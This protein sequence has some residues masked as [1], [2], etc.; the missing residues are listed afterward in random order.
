MN[1]L[2]RLP[3]IGPVVA[4]VTRT[5]A[6][7]VY[8]HFDD[9][10]SNRMAGSVTFFGFLALFPLLTVALAVA[11]SVLSDSRVNTLQ[12]K[13]AEQIPGLSKQLNLHEVAANAT[14]VGL[15]SGVI[16]LIS[17][18][19][20]V[21]TTRVSI[22]TSW[23]L[24]LEPGNV[25]VRKFWDTVMLIGLGV[26][27]AISLAASTAA[28][29]LTGQAAR[30]LGLQGSTG[31]RVALAVVAFVL[32]VAVDLMVFSYVLVGLPRIFGQ[33]RRV[34]LEAALLGAIGFEILKQA[35]A[36]YIA[37]VATKSVYG[38]FGTP[39]ALLLWINFMCRWLLYCVAWTATADPEAARLRARQ[40]AVEAVAKADED[41]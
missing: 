31:G 10:G 24:P 21:D 41:V 14:T 40:R 6:Y 38:A 36:A 1:Q 15:V 28:G 8:E 5:R 33:P 29:S 20:W 25:I 35:L 30:W 32:A 22:R 27:G 17:G 12:Q 3:L 39:I 26:V 2:T 37:G 4:R 11:A 7:R 16:L 23:Y 18:L 19:G 9:V 34:V 13:I